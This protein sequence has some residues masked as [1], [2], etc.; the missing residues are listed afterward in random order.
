MENALPAV[1]FSGGLD[2]AKLRINLTYRWRH[3]RWP[4]LA[5]PKTFT[6]LIQLRKLS[7]RD[8]R[9][10]V[11]ADKVLAKNF[12]AEL[13]GQDWIIPTLWDGPILPAA[14]D[15]PA[16]FVVKSRHGCNQRAFVRTGTE[17]WATIRRHAANWMRVSYG[18]WLDEWAYS[19][20]PRGILVEPFV[21][22]DGALPIDWKIYVFGGRARFVQVHLER[23]THHHWIVMH[24]D[25]FRVSAATSEPDPAA[26]SS[27]ARMLAA[28]ETLAAGFDFVRVDFY[29]IGGQPLFGEMTFYPGSG[30]DRFDPVALD[31]AMGSAWLSG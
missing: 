1:T 21:S 2:L 11:L 20:I 3:G 13:L 12:A 14:A 16:P 30:L 7:S 17:D 18:G 8:A 15:W 29:E 10:P 4:D 19:Q 24:R 27:L 6:E 26:P 31:R 22:E 9:M 23:E 5:N 25:W 28:A